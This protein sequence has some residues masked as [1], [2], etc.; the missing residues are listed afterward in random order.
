MALA[1]L[2]LLCALPLSAA[3]ANPF[4]DVPDNAWYKEAVDYVYESGLF[5]GTSSST[6]TPGK[7]MTRGMFVQVLA[8]MTTNYDAGYYKAR[9]SYY[10]DVLKKSWMSA[11]VRWASDARIVNGTSVTRFSPDRAL[12]REQMAVMLFNYAEK[13]GNSVDYSTAKAGSFSDYTSVSSW[14]KQAIAW[15]VDNGV[16]NGT[17]GL[18]N[19]KGTATRAQV[20][21]VFMN[22]KELF[23]N[24]A[25]DIGTP[26]P[27][28]ANI[29]MLFS[30]AIG[31]DMGKLAIE[32]DHN[33][34]VYISDSSY[35]HHN[36]RVI[37]LK[38]ENE[39][40]AYLSSFMTSELALGV[41]AEAE[42]H[43]KN[44]SVY[45]TIA[46]HGMTTGFNADS[47]KIVSGSE[48]AYAV[49]IDIYF[50]I[51]TTYG[52]TSEM[53]LVYEN[54][55]YKIAGYNDYYEVSNPVAIGDWLPHYLEY[56]PW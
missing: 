46:P 14:A 22:A 9:D 43:A 33:N 34:P 38:D 27:T 4:T 51:P 11:A 24:K 50:F 41:L 18:L 56:K 23:V 5:D 40:A 32:Y 3:A 37:G 8:N 36:Y 48:G 29:A 13:S 28:K 44:G 26:E 19:P 20:A 42:L 55:E 6:F 1:F 15:A 30:R 49:S 53:N 10:T 17:D 31:L 35:P 2:M 47:V 12:T 52:G 16:I 45:I 25:I 21:Q 7:A 54:G 39:I